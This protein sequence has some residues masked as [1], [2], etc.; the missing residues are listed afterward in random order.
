MHNDKPKIACLPNGP[1]YLLNDLTPQTIP[2]LQD[3]KGDPCATVT[4]AALCRCGGSSNKPFC[5]GTHGKNGF[6]DEKE[7]DG[8]LDK[9]DKY[10][11]KSITIHDN[12]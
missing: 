12:R 4:G 6:T 7:T 10:A 5:D 11:G 9:R 8:K 2:T 1:Y 3:A